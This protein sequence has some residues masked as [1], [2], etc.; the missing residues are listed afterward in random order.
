MMGEAEI[1]E[2]GF[3]FVVQEDIPQVEIAVDDLV[4]VGVD[5]AGADS[6]G[7]EQCLF[8]INGFA[9]GGMPE[10]FSRNEFHDE[11]EHPFDVARVIDADQIGVIQLCH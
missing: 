8:E 3:G 5:E 2:F 7:E 9:F 10:G 6:L 1:G 4:L 11:I